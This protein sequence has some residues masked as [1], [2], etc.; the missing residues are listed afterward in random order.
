LGGRIVDLIENPTPGRKTGK[1]IAAFDVLETVRDLLYKEAPAE[2]VDELIRGVLRHERRARLTAE[3]L[4][5]AMAALNSTLDLNQVLALILEQLQQVVQFDSASLM[6]IEGD[7]I[8]IHAVRGHP[9]PDQALQVKFVARDNPLAWEIISTK[10]SLILADALEDERFQ[11]LGDA[12]FV[13]GWMGIPMIVREEVIGMLTVDSR[14]MNAY[15]REDAQLAMTF[16]SQA[17]LAAA[18]ARLYQS[19]HEQRTLAQVLREISLVLSGSLD[20]NQILE[21]MLEQ[22]GKVVPYDSASVMM[23][24]ATTC[25]S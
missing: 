21:V 1:K 10:K 23:L 3:T 14:M 18:N 11:R 9:N 20:S 5:R 17:A 13:R 4:Q 6:L 12:N 19:E 15:S 22:V 2:E 8:R 16:A 24:E 25:E 7:K